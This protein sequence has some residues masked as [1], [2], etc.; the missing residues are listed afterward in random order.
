[1]AATQLSYPN[2]YFVARFNKAVPRLHISGVPESRCPRHF[3]VG[4]PVV[5]IL[6]CVIHQHRDPHLSTG[7]LIRAAGIA[8]ICRRV[9]GLRALA[10][11]ILSW[12][13]RL[14][15]ADADQRQLTSRQLVARPRRRMRFMNR[16]IDLLEAELVEERLM[17]RRGYAF[18]TADPATHATSSAEESNTGA[19]AA[20]YV[21]G[22][23]LSIH[24]A[25]LNV[26]T[27]SA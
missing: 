8:G 19:R 9:S 15:L 13:R 10:L 2:L 17:N 26:E 22:R 3:S 12:L 1:M 16:S 18:P 11:P 27:L 4:R 21:H 7:H 20:S 5:P 24:P 23:S 25:S 6:S 14:Q